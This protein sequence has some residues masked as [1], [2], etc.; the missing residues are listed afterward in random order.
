MHPHLLRMTQVVAQSSR[1]G[2][3]AVIGT[4]IWSDRTEQGEYSGMFIAWNTVKLLAGKLMLIWLYHIIKLDSELYILVGWNKAQRPITDR[5]ICWL[6]PKVD[7][8]TDLSFIN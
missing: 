4:R 1:I 7:H 3:P 2:E 6:I 5:K 8:F